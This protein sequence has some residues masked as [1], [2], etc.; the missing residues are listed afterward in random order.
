MAGNKRYFPANIGHELSIGLRAVNVK[1]ALQKALQKGARRHQIGPV[2]SP[3]SI[4]C[5]AL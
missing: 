1:F 2:K 3:L 5:G 4:S